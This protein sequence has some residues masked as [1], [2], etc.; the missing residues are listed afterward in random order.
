M[1][2]ILLSFFALFL[3]AGVMA[4]QDKPITIMQL[5]DKA[6]AFLKENFP[7][8]E[9]ALIT[10]D[11]DLVY[12]DYEVTLKDGTRIDFDSKGSW[13]EVVVRGGM[14]PTVLVPVGIVTYV[15]DNHKGEHIKRIDRDRRTFEVELSSGIEL[16]FDKH[17]RL[18]D[19]DD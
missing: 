6:Q 4:A 12:K 14:V 7:D 13:Q 3:C 18:I 11:D 2:R 9:V 10:Q 8:V 17:C 1:K 19:I 16:T 15:V 5:P